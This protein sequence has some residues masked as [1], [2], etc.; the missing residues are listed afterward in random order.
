M[1]DTFLIINT[2]NPSEFWN[3]D[4]GWGDEASATTFTED[5]RHRLRLPLDGAWTLPF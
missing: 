1:S 3:N 4:T 2:L 5:E